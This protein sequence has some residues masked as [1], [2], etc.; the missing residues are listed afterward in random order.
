MKKSYVMDGRKGTTGAL[1]FS[2]LLDAPAGKHGYLGISNDHFAFEDGT[3]IRFFGTNLS[4]GAAMPDSDAAK[5]MAQRLACTGV[6]MVRLH[7]ADSYSSDGTQGNTL[8]DYSKGNSR[9]MDSKAFDRLDFL[10][11]QLKQKGI[12]IHIDLFVARNFLPGDDLDYP[13]SLVF[14]KPIKQ[15][16]VFN[17]RLITLQKE[18][19]TQYLTHLNPYTGLRYVDDPAVAVVQVMNE[20]SIYWSIEK[21]APSYVAELDA[22]W[23]GWLRERYTDTKTLDKAWT[24]LDGA[25]TLKNGEDL[26]RGNIG[27]PFHGSGG[28]PHIDW[29]TDYLGVQSP[30]RYADHIEFLEEIQ[31]AFS[32]DMRAHL[33]EL[34]VKC[35]INISNH[36]KGPSDTYAISAGEEVTENNGYWNHPMAGH[37]PPCEFH[38]L[39]M[40]STDPRN[41]QVH[42]FKLN[43]VT[44]LSLDRVKGKPFIVTEW[45]NCYPTEF[46]SDAM[47]MLTAYGALQDWDGLLLYSYSHFSSL[48]QMKGECIQGFWNVYNDPST[49]GQMGICSA[50]FQLGYVKAAEKTIELC[51]TPQDH[52]AMAE[53]W[54]APFGFLPYVSR[55][56]TTF[57]NPKYDGK[58]NLALASGFTPT[59]DLTAAQHAFAYS[60]SPYVDGHQKNDMLQLYIDKHIE[61][62][63]MIYRN[64]SIGQQRAV[65]SDGEA[66][67]GNAEALSEALDFSMKH[68]GI[69]KDTQGLLGQKAI[70]SDTEQLHFHFAEGSFTIRAERFGAYVGHCIPNI[71]LG[72]IILNLVNEKMA[73]SLFP[74]DQLPLSE[75]LHMLLTAVGKCGNEDM[76]WKG[77]FLLDGGRGPVWIDQAEGAL[78]FHR[79]KSTGADSCKVYAL[80]PDGSRTILMPSHKTAE[81]T[82][83]SLGQKE[84]AICYEIVLET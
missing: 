11:W 23:N 78:L 29:K 74:L 14:G 43:L 58:A 17:R 6:N 28:Q 1:D 66:F 65:M 81:G 51:Y 50:I 8:I 27:R 68:W 57:I 67:E 53:N 59:G 40:V 37:Q 69:W 47:T 64:L 20:N 72:R 61:S 79:T 75:S 7:Y 26:A 80:A 34:G 54:I 62:D 36:S 38:D 84:N 55:I 49:W 45:N 48:D 60:R 42:P 46:S 22:R 5:V 70:V 15:L 3:T 73:I 41:T 56:S 10:I 30:A 63:S 82:M 4:A 16:N 25:Q 12:Y 24:R 19:A 76:I 77:N 44:R 18:Y 32:M 71:T 35:P 13:D 31:L 9:S 2:W 39:Q 21:E 83:V 33:L 52:L